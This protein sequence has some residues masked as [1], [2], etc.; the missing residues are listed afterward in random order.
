MFVGIRQGGKTNTC[1]YF[2]S[3]SSLPYTVWDEIGAFSKII[4]PM[5]PQTQ[6]I[7]NPS[8]LDTDA[9]LALLHQTCKRVMAEGKQLFVIDEVHQY[10]T[11]C[12]LDK[13]L[14]RVITL[15][16]NKHIGVTCTSQSVRQVHNTII[17]NTMHFFIMKTF[18][19][20]DVDWLSAFVPKEYV[21]LSQSLP[22][23][24]FIYYKLGGKPLIC[25]PVKKMQL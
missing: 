9:K 6:R 4:R 20:P 5:Y 17:G 16:G 19:K 1:A 15:G 11:K 21:L 22:P 25:A 24:A 14:E 23:Y 18:L 3:R 12:K 10:C 2:L 7:I 13:E 8:M